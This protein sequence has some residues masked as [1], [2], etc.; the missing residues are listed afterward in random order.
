[1]IFDSRLITIT[2]NGSTGPASV[3]DYDAAP[4]KANPGGTD[5]GKTQG[6]TVN[7]NP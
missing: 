7:R 1:M 6:A 3:S 5:H 2:V 4:S